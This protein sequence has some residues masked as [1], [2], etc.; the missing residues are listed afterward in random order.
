MLL[1]WLSWE[2]LAKSK[3]RG[4]M[5]FREISDFNKALLGKHG[6]RLV[7]GEHTLIDGEG[8]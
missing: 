1:H 5:E 3:S 2:R 6:W 4:G 7:N 8:L